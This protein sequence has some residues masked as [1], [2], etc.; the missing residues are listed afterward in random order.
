MKRFADIAFAACLVL[1]L[2]AVAL[3][4]F[5]R[6]SGETSFFEN[7]AL[8]ERPALT[9]EGVASGDYFDQ[10]EEWFT[11]HAVGR[12]TLLKLNTWLEMELLGMP[13]V[14]DV[15]ITPDCLLGY[16][17]YNR[18]DTD[19]LE[20]EA[21]DFAASLAD[22][23]AYVEE[24]G[25]VFCFVGLP[26]QYGYFSDKSRDW[27]ESR[28]WYLEPLRQ[29]VFSAMEEAGV[30]A[31]DGDALFTSLGHPDRFYAASDHHFTYEGAW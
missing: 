20:E 19:F 31:L 10:W 12:T 30:A 2:A 26:E 15:V 8:A 18:W 7:R 11:D 23:S 17:S 16:N 28:A 5:L 4:T 1:F 27:L 14:N 22:L 6:N 9:A 25:G 13:V 24:R 3:G 29:A 21:A